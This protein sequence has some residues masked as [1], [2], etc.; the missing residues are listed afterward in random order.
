VQLLLELLLELW[1]LLSSPPLLPLSNQRN[2]RELSNIVA[3]ALLA[4][5]ILFSLPMLLDP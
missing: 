1:R 2:A 5:A 3:A 4:A